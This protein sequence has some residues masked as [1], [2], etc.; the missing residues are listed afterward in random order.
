LDVSCV[1]FIPASRKIRVANALTAILNDLVA[2]PDNLMI[3][4]KY[5]C[6][7]KSIL[8]YPVE[9][10]KKPSV[11][12]G[13][14]LDRWDLDW[15]KTFMDLENRIRSAAPKSVSQIQKDNLRRCLKFV[16]LARCGDALKTLLSNGTHEDTEA[17]WEA[18]LKKHPPRDQPNVKPDCPA[19]ISVTLETLISCAKSFKK[20][21]AAGASG[22]SSDH[23]RQL[24]FRSEK[25]G[26]VNTNLANASLKLVNL[27]LQGRLPNEIAPFFASASLIALRK[28]DDGVRPI[29]IGEF[30]RRVV[31]KATMLYLKPQCPLIFENIQLGVNV[32]NACESIIHDLNSLAEQ[33]E[34]NTKVLLKIDWRNAFNEVSREVF[35][36]EC[37]K[38]APGISGL[39]EWLYSGRPNLWYQGRS[40]PSCDGTQQGDPLGPF[41][42][43]IAQQRILRPLAKRFLEIR[44]NKFFMDDGNIVL[45]LKS[46]PSLLKYFEEEGAKIGLKLNIEKCELWAPNL[47]EQIRSYSVALPPLKIVPDAGVVVLGGPVSTQPSFFEKFFEKKVNATGELISTIMDQV[48][49]AQ[50]RL[51]LLRSCIA[52]PQ[53][54]YHIRVCPTQHIT[55]SL[56]R[57]DL[58]I[59]DSMSRLCGGMLD[60]HAGT[61]FSLPLSRGGLGLLSIK[62]IAPAAFLGSVAQSHNL[63]SVQTR[64]DFAQCLDLYKTMLS[65]LSY[66]SAVNLDLDLTHLATLAKPQASL[67]TPILEG[68]VSSFEAQISDAPDGNRLKARWESI[69]DGSAKY[70][71]SCFPSNK[72][73]IFRSSLFSAMIR[74]HLGLPHFSSAVTRGRLLN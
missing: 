32:P 50:T 19:G 10:S 58:L 54:G 56:E 61:Q 1:V 29:A 57:Y 12:M 70:A 62:Q 43:S 11:W 64:G 40:I 25:S 71:F 5:F 15:L 30:F 6:F 28:P 65:T 4:A 48:D 3:W 21:S 22:F 14:R 69:K 44:Y 49:D 74:Q 18:L 45:P 36:E 24:L 9:S 67:S 46:V 52:Y 8:S 42:F 26:D 60:S 7:C 2:A 53:L 20:G 55:A 39:V 16:S 13:E 73:T 41:L 59:K 34:L 66:A 27:I 37:R 33:G 35:F 51:H 47:Q 17:T 72:K 31:A 23:Y 63:C 68:Q 38:Y